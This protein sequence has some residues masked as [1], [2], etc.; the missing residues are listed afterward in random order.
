[1]PTSRAHVGSEAVRERAARHDGVLVCGH[2]H[3]SPSA[4]QIG[5]CLCLNVGGLGEPWGEAQVGFVTWRADD[6][7]VAEHEN[8]SSGAVRKWTREP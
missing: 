8:L 5:R 3:E 4:V 6:R 1:V 7:H 2:I